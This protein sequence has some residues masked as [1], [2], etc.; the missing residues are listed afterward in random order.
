MIA[1]RRQGIVPINAVPM[2]PDA[3]ITSVAIGIFFGTSFFLTS[4]FLE[5]KLYQRWKSSDF[6]KIMFG[7][8]VPTAEAAKTEKGAYM[9]NATS[10]GRRLKKDWAK[11]AKKD[12]D[13]QTEYWTGRKIR[14]EIV[15]VGPRNYP[16]QGYRVLF[17]KDE[18]GAIKEMVV[19]SKSGKEEYGSGK[20]VKKRASATTAST[21]STQSAAGSTATAAPTTRTPY[22]ADWF[23]KNVLRY[24][25]KTNFYGSPVWNYVTAARNISLTTLSVGD[26]EVQLVDGSIVG[27]YKESG[28]NRQ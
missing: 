11:R 7:I 25:S 12:Y 16:K 2:W 3:L 28:V 14:E 26:Y 27:G 21:A 15:G 1:L 4:E 24:R 19:G 10:T 18:D 20:V 23:D 6:Y 22:D 5:S 9:P 13:F 17:T 8:V